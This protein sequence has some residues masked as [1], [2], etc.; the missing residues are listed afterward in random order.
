MREIYDL[1]Q[2]RAFWTEQA[3]TH[4][5]AP[6]AS[7]SDVRVMEMEVRE[8][9]KY[10]SDDDHVLDAGC[11][12]GFSTVQFARHRKIHIRGLDYIPEMI[13]EAQRRLG[14]LSNHLRGT[15]EFA[16][17]DITALAE[18]DAAY[19]KVITIRVL[20]NLRNWDLQLRAL[21]E[22]AR[23]L[24]PGGTLLV[25][26][27]TVQGWRRLNTFRRE[28]GLSDIPVPA[29]NEY[30]D[31]EKLKHELPTE[32][33]LTKI[34]NFASSYYV[35]TRVLKPLLAKALGN[36][37]DPADPNM[38]WNRW[39]AELPPWGDY[40]TQKLFAFEKR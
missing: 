7:W 24:K 18:P 20:I 9:L 21:R 34:V 12:N 4:G 29:F 1:E 14:A 27:A 25:S 37:I 17:G 38:E 11:A 39:S 31:E 32:L 35:A 23:V 19:D 36:G 10:L 30:L 3:K 8:I 16:Q 28:W 6:T 13:A 2:I 26:E 5:Q 33:R 40:G 22:C 15:V